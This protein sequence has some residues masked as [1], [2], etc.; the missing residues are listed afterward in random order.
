MRSNGA[1]QPEL[2]IAVHLDEA[3]A[4]VDRSDD[5]QGQRRQQHQAGL[6]QLVKG[7][8]KNI[9]S[10]VDAESRIGHAERPAV[11]K[12]Q[13]RVPLA[14][15]AKREQQPDA[16]ADRHRRRLQELEREIDAGLCD[17]VGAGPRPGT[18]RPSAA[19][20]GGAVFHRL[21]EID[22]QKKGR[23]D[24]R[25]ARHRPLHRKKRPEDAGVV[26]LAHPQPF[27]QV[28]GDASQD[29]NEQDRSRGHEPKQTREGDGASGRAAGCERARPGKFDDCA[30]LD[31]R[32]PLQAASTHGG[33]AH[34]PA[35]RRTSSS[36]VCAYLGIGAACAPA[37]RQVG[38]LRQR[39]SRN[40]RA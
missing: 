26:E 30:F 20:Q 27:L 31:H 38:R 11:T 5:R 25:R 18:P 40:P 9:E 14:E 17:G 3:E 13:I 23:E 22:P 21:T 16:G 6:Q 19:A 32:P 28:A 24:E 4:E 10:D 7:Q 12:S 36:Q 15:E 39:L 8:T 35:D 34:G 37:L 2:A 33:S 29:D 1:V